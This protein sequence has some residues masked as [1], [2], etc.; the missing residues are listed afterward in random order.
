MPRSRGHAGSGGSRHPVGRQRPLVSPAAGPAPDGLAIHFTDITGHRKQDTEPSVSSTFDCPAAVRAARFGELTTV[1]TE[2]LTVQDVVDA[3]AAPRTAFVRSQ[4]AAVPAHRERPP[5]HG[6]VRRLP[7]RGRH[8]LGSTHETPGTRPACGRRAAARR[9]RRSAASWPEHRSARPAATFPRAEVCLAGSGPDLRIRQS[10]PCTS[11]N[12][13]HTADAPL[14]GV[15][16]RRRPVGP[17][18]C[19]LGASRRATRRRRREV[20]AA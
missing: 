5:A 8:R 14:P 10:L 17:A 12:Y 9:P 19:R 18:R 11:V 13:C 3:V 2:A 1:L 4:R 20:R 7:P 15:M 6:R 16:K